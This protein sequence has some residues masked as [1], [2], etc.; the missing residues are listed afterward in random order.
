[1]KEQTVT[2]RKLTAEEGMTL[3]NG[4]VFGKTVYLGKHDSPEN[5]QELPDEEAA[6]LQAQAADSTPEPNWQ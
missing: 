5:W 6:D 3:Y 1:M 2:L 4:A